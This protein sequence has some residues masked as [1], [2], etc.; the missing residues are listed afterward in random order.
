MPQMQSVNSSNV[1]S[2]G[3]VA[4]YSALYVKFNTGSTYRYDDVPVEVY[5][6]LINAASVGQ[7]L[8]QNIKGVYSYQ[9][10]S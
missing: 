1:D 8:N 10:I 5:E 7:Y 3:Y 4:E 2:V 9:K 6:G